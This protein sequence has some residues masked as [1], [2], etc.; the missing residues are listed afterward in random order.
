MFVFNQAE[1]KELQAITDNI[2]G[3][4]KTLQMSLNTESFC[5][6]CDELCEVCPECNEERAGEDVFETAMANKYRMR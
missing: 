4:C 1:L 2:L 5:K 3:I 6:D